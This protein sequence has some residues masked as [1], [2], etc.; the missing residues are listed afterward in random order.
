VKEKQEMKQ[1]VVATDPNTEFLLDSEP[2]NLVDLRPGMRVSFQPETGVAT[3]VSAKTMTAK[4]QKEFKEKK[5]AQ[6]DAAGQ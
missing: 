2:A 5:A 1:V 3:R 6:G 4:E